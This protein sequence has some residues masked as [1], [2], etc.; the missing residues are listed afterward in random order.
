MIRFTEKGQLYYEQ[1]SA[2]RNVTSLKTLASLGDIEQRYGIGTRLYFSFLLWTILCNAVL[3]I[4]GIV[5]WSL[6]LRDLQDRQFSW[7]DFFTSAYHPE[8]DNYWFICGV[9]AFVV[10]WM[11]GPIYYLWERHF[12]RD[13]YPRRRKIT[14][15]E[16]QITE[17]VGKRPDYFFSTMFSISYL[18]M[19]SL[20]LYG[21][22]HAQNY[23]IVT[24]G[25]DTAVVD[26]APLRVGTAM[27]LVVALGFAICHMSWGHV[28]YQVTRSENNPTWFLFRM[29]QAL[30]LIGFKILLSTI[31]YVM[32]VFVIAAEDNSVK[33]CNLQFAGVNFFLVLVIDVILTFSLQTLWPLLALRFGLRRPEFNIAEDLLQILFRQFIVYIGF[34]AFP[35]IGL[36]GFLANLAEYFVDRYRLAQICQD[37]HYLPEKPGGF[38]L[39]FTLVVAGAAFITYPNGAL[40]MLFLPQLLPSSLQNCTVVGAIYRT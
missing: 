30:K 26:G 34:F 21:L 5:S 17:N 2:D 24:Y 16:Q 35:L 1:T 40:W 6:F 19:S 36:L 8:S 3:A 39:I 20:L 10:W 13:A 18:A 12:K 9:L 33:S 23:V 15:E 27:T 25:S 37:P 32:L 22:I 38:L 11:V 28:S 14:A 31:M 4:L 7:G 29:S